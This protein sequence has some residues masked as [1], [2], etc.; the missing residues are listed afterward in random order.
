[1]RSDVRPGI[2]K[3]GHVERLNEPQ[4]GL[5]AA[6]PLDRDEILSR[7]AQVE[8]HFRAERIIDR[9]IDKGAACRH[10]A[11]AHGVNVVS[12]ENLAL[13]NERMPFRVARSEVFFLAFVLT[14][15]Q[16]RLFEAD[17]VGEAALNDFQQER[18]ALFGRAIELCFVREFQAD[19]TALDPDDGGLEPR[20]FAKAKFDHFPQVWLEIAADLRAAARQVQDLDAVRAAFAD[21]ARGFAFEPMA[22]A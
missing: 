17:L 1:M 7:I 5:V 21:D 2:R 14:E 4:A 8:K 6:H 22:V 20:S 13:P 18:V 10:V 9:D 12:V 3:A 19:A 16:F 11:D 15:Q